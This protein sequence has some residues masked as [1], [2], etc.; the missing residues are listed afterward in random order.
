[1]IEQSSGINIFSLFSH[2]L[3]RNLLRNEFKVNVLILFES[4]SFQSSGWEGW[5][6]LCD[7]LMIIQLYLSFPPHL[8]LVLVICAADILTQDI[9]KRSILSQVHS[10]TPRKPFW[11]VVHSYRMGFFL[12]CCLHI[13]LFFYTALCKNKVFD[14]QD[15]DWQLTKINRIIWKIN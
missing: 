15:K 7:R 13:N 3:K 10:W 6:V 5:F 4:R 12:F 9:T 2:C 1:M 11:E 8:T 14:I